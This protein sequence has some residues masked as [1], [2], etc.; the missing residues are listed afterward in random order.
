[1]L[2]TET[3]KKDSVGDAQ[4]NYSWAPEGVVMICFT[5]GMRSLLCLFVLRKNLDISWKIIGRFVLIT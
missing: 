4:L 1:M 5:S 3:I 2:S